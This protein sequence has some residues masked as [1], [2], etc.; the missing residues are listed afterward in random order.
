MSNILEKNPVIAETKIPPSG[1][2]GAVL[3]K[4]GNVITA[5][6]NYVADIFIEGETISAIGKNLN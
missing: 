3:I 5:T 1:G 6:D 2:G 4:K